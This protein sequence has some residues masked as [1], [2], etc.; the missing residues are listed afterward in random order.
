MQMQKC[1][2][3]RGE[4]FSAYQAILFTS[5]GP[6]LLKLWGN[7]VLTR[8]AKGDAAWYGDMAAIMAI[9]ASSMARHE[10]LPSCRGLSRHY[11]WPSVHRSSAKCINLKLLACLLLISFMWIIK[12]VLQW[13]LKCNSVI[14][15]RTC[16]G[17]V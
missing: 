3:W 12:M 10:A 13:Y 8:D 4:S 5:K 2:Q 16:P 1:H 11:L 6:S 7:S 15:C 14:C 17:A 9:L